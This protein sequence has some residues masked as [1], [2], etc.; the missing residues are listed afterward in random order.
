V[1]PITVVFETEHAVTVPAKEVSQHAS[2]F[3]VGA[4][5]RVLFLSVTETSPIPT[6]G[7]PE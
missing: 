4:P 6:G 3:V 5:E 7:V 1:T 2:E